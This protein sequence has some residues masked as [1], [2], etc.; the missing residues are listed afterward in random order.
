M[1][2]RVLDG[3]TLKS[4]SHVNLPGIRVNLP[5]ITEHDKRHV[6]F[7]MEQGVDFIALSFVREAKDVMELREL[8][9]DMNN[10]IKIIS[11]IEEQEG[12]KNIDGIIDVSDAVMVARGDLGIEI[13]LFSNTG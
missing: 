6:K 10:K 2:C 1:E 9:G 11:K 7:G 12:V 13:P 3:G 4:Q 5:S 8:L